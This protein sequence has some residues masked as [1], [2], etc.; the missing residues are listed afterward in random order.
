MKER[1]LSFLSNI[2]QKMR[3]IKSF[4]LRLVNQSAREFIVDLLNCWWIE[5]LVLVPYNGQFNLPVRQAK[6]RMG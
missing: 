1:C 6:R 3:E 4:L 5:I 2:R